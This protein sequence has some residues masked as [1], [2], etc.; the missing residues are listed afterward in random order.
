M[1][2]EFSL[3]FNNKSSLYSSIDS[4][5]I[6]IKRESNSGNPLLSRFKDIEKVYPFGE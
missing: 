1:C 4:E 3:F 5:P 6:E 2:S